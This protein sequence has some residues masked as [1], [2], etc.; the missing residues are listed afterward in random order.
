MQRT[1]R[2]HERELLGNELHNVRLPYR[3]HHTI[4]LHFGASLAGGNRITAWPGL[5]ELWF[6]TARI[7]R[8]RRPG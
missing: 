3:G 8:L 5:H 6:R 7:I 4:K 2:P 1:D